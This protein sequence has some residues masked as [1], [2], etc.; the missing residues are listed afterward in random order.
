MG[1]LLIW[2]TLKLFFVCGARCRARTASWFQQDLF[3]RASRAFRKS[4]MR[5]IIPLFE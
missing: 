2:F 4:E 3:E 5:V 1:A